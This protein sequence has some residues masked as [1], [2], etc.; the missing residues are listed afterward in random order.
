[1]FIVA[2]GTGS[3]PTPNKHD[4]AKNWGA[5]EWIRPVIDIMMAGASETTEFHLGK[6]FSVGGNSDQYV[7]IQPSRMGNASLDMDNATNLNIR[8][9]IGVGIET[10]QNCSAELDR[11]VDILLQGEDPVE[12]E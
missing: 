9:L 12:F 6:M 1:M 2:L 8:E 7:R 11:I 10:A 3:Q 4:K 5:V